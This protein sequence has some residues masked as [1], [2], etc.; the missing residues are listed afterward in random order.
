M[1]LIIDCSI[2]S[3]RPCLWDSKSR[4]KADNTFFSSYTQMS[5]KNKTPKEPN[6]QATEAADVFAAHDAAVRTSGAA[7][8]AAAAS[9]AGGTRRASARI[10]ATA[11]RVALLGD[12]D[13]QSSSSSVERL[14]IDPNTNNRPK[15]RASGRTKTTKAPKVKKTK[16]KST[17][18]TKRSDKEE[19][20]A[21]PPP[22]K[23][24]KLKTKP[25]SKA[26][27]TKSTKSNKSTAASTRS[28]PAAA[29]KQAQAEGADTRPPP[30]NTSSN[31]VTPQA[32]EHAQHEV[33][34]IVTNEMMTSDGY[35]DEPRYATLDPY[36]QTGLV[37]HAAPQTIPAGKLPRRRDFA[38]AMADHDLAGY[39]TETIQAAYLARCSKEQ[40]TAAAA[41]EATR[42]QEAN[43]R[44][45]A[46]MPESGGAVP[47]RAD[48]AAPS[49]TRVRFTDPQPGQ[50]ASPAVSV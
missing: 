22:P 13:G 34:A 39:S 43:R 50:T 27:S 40:V 12:E 5:G 9:A 26:K 33:D 47:S 7:I 38:T 16:A 8:V 17:K 11:S 37:S 24:S 42:D 41:L 3:S 15:R 23:P 48:P 4:R 49:G 28:K 18:S 10:A 35:D 31:I 30:P 32:A 46:A 45:R 1:I 29:P 6:F 19:D 14:V 36:A 20:D 2:L 21:S 44:R 25:K